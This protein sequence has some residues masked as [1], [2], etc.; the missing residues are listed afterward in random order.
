ML[1]TLAIQNYALIQELTIDF[2][3]G[4]SIITGETGAGKS[5][6]LGALSLL[7]G[8]RADTSVLLDQS[9]K[10]IV[11]GTF[12]I[13]GY[14]LE[15]MFTQYELDFDNTSVIRR[16]ISP[17][18]KSRA[19]VNDSPVNLSILKDL[20]ERLID[21]HSQHQNQYL[22]NSQFQLRVLD[23]F[24]GHSEILQ[25]YRDTFTHY[26]S[27]KTEHQNISDTAAK[28]K[29]DLD[30]F[31]FQYD[32]LQA[33]RLQDDELDALEKEL[34][35][36]THSEEI[37]SSLA[38]ASVALSGETNSVVVLLKDSLVAFSKIKGFYSPAIELQTRLES[39]FLEIKD[40]AHETEN[41]C[42]HI[43]HDPVRI[44]FVKQRLD[45][46]YSL[47]QKHRCGSMPELISVRNEFKQKIDEISTTDSRLEEL[48]KEI[49]K[50]RSTL[51]NI[52][53][54]ISGNRKK[55]I[56]SI[57][58][59][60]LELL[61]Q[62]GISNGLFKVEITTT[63]DFTSNGTDKVRFLFSANK[64][65]I[66]QELAK[67]ASGG[68]MARLMLSIKA[69]ISSAI[70]LPTIIFDEIDAGVSG[71]IADKMGNVIYHMSESAQIINITH[72]PQIASKGENHYFVY[73]QDLDN[74]TQTSIKK[75]KSEERI[76]EIARM[77]SGE[78]LSDAAINNAKTLLGVN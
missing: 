60:V 72:L 59:N 70:I 32:Q 34:T 44:D 36:L 66:L 57:E 64:Q 78:Q 21:I 45:L 41:L 24:A 37:K 8:Q 22:E 53:A 47:L 7:V 35:L 54:A 69:T 55:V 50:V 9:R 76:V 25:H 2:S 28:N 68:E 48:K 18:G 65:G 15:D 29:A 38:G 39:I 19:F 77:L 30:Y 61:R 56:S 1:T 20:G 62:L 43:D 14:G 71:D 6:L 63:D 13:N 42:E 51:E 52:A 10:C 17:D 74:K 49:D 12:Q 31:Q 16:E 67:V 58:N 75:L 27:L 33:A 5:I 73:K 11:E 26:R 40:I 23:T 46:L 3:K 4:L